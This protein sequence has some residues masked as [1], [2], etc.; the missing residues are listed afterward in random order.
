MLAASDRASLCCCSLTLRASGVSTR[1]TVFARATMFEI[2]TLRASVDDARRLFDQ[3]VA[4][5]IEQQPGF[6]GMFV[7]LTPEGKG[8]VL[9]LWDNEQ[10]AQSGLESGYYEE[11]IAR[12]VTFVRQSPGREHYEVIR[13]QIASDDRASGAPP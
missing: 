6:A 9:T 10:A 12:F 5:L 8:M 4:P 13:A 3:Q 2:D 11:Q 7:M 1:N